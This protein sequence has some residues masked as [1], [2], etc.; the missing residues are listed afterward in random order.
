MSWDR[1]EIKYIS[2]HNLKIHLE[3]TFDQPVK[4]IWAHG[5]LY[6]RYNT[7]QKYAIDLWEDMCGFFSGTA[8][9]YFMVWLMSKMQN[10]TNLNHACPIT[11][12][13]FLKVNNISANQFTI[14]PLLPAGRYRFDLDLTKLSRNN[15]IRNIYGSVRI[16]ASISDH[17]I[18]QV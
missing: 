18:E 17:R 15:D 1:C 9:S 13:V 14:E 8:H 3:S 12:T 6:Y 16:F 7:Y 11:G 4:T 5:I 10:F 2:R